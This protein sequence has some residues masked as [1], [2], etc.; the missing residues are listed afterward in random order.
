MRKYVMFALKLLVSFGI[1]FAT[2]YQLD[3]EIFL[4]NL[5]RTDLRWIGAALGL[6]T[7]SYFLGSFQWKLI[8]GMSEIILPYARVLGYYYVGLFF[9][10][11]LLSGLGG[12]LLRIYD[13]QKHSANRERLSPALASVIFDRFTGLLTLVFLACL[14][15]ALVIGQGESKR[16]FVSIAALFV[17]WIFGLVILFNKEVADRTVK[18]LARILPDRIYTRLQHLYYEI[19][20][21]HTHPVALFKVFG[22]S[23]IVQSLRIL[24]IWAIGR[25]MGDQSPVVYYILFVPIISLAA[26]LPISIGGTGPREQT[27]IFLFRRIGVSQEIAFSIGLV[28][29]AVSTMSALPGALVFLLRKKHV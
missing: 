10:N 22:V 20:N 2:L 18:P 14:S 11:F 9:N 15:G 29:Y 4:A 16:M 5:A 7:L 17:A 25:A 3:T 8:L 12:D 21:F 6:L 23:L 26:S 13:I 27:T 1:I 28:T 19:N 24:S